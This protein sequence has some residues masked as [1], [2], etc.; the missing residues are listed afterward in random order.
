MAPVLPRVY[1]VGPDCRTPSFE[2]KCM[3]GQLVGGA[4]ASIV[5][6]AAA[7]LSDWWN[8]PVECIDVAVVG[9]AVAIDA[10]GWTFHRVRTSAACHPRG[11]ASPVV[12][13]RCERTLLTSAA[14]T[15]AW[16]LAFVINRAIHA[17]ATSIDALRAAVDEHRGRRGIATVRDALELVVAGSFGTRCFTEDCYVD[18]FPRHGLPM[19]I[20]NVRG[21]LGIPRDE[22]DFVWP[23]LRVNVESD[24]GHHDQP[25]QWSD[26]QRRDEAA[27]ALGWRV[28]R[29]RARDFHR[30]RSVVMRAVAAFV[31]GG[32]VPTEPDSRVLCI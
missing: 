28:L 2:Q 22:P 10:D 30:R 18:E 26:D 11:S 24:G 5:G 14:A 9:R 1:A 20:V 17:G 21:A 27:I 19:P 8:R 6:L 7:S 32:Q 13:P 4:G 3:A 23:E 15:T 29:V 25:G 31:R 12:V 16:Q